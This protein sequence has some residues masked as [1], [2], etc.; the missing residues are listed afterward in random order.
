M[1]QLSQFWYSEKTI[2]DI[3]ALVGKVVK[4]EDQVALL[5]CP[6]LYISCKAVHHNTKIFEFDERFKIWGDDFVKYDFNNAFDE[7]YLHEFSEKFDLIIADPPFLS[8]ECMQKISFI[9]KKMLKPNGKILV[10]SGEVVEKYIVEFL[11]LKKCGYNPEHTR[12]LGNEFSTF[13]NFDS[14]Y[15]LK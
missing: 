9:I 14:D 12:N 2:N 3:S 10:C 13:S 5:S 15:F 8:D 7:N 1:Q 4:R 11:G 6:S